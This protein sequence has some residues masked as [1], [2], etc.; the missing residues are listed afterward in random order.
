MLVD[1]VIFGK[2]VL[3]R[4]NRDEFD[5]IF[6]DIL[7]YQP[8]ESYLKQKWNEF[9]NNQLSFLVCYKDFTEVAIEKMKEINY[10]G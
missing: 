5:K 9:C 3:N 6:E 2:Y 10:K 8:H 1:F 7:S 4:I